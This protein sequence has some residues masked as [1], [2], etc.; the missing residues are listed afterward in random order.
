MQ[1]HISKYCL[2]KIRRHNGTWDEHRWHR[3]K[4]LILSLMEVELWFSIQTRVPTMGNCGKGS[5]CLCTW[6]LKLWE[7]YLCSINI[8]DLD[9]IKVGLPEEGFWDFHQQGPGEEGPV[10]QRRNSHG[11]DIFCLSSVSNCLL[12]SPSYYFYLS[13]LNLLFN[14]IHTIDSSCGLICTLTQAEAFLIIKS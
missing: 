8:Q 10:G 2:H 1:L 9:C 13:T 3:R 11:G 5:K 4:E 6:H 7:W 14:K 12:S